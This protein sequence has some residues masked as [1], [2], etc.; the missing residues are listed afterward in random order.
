MCVCVHVCM[1]PC[2]CVN[3]HKTALS[4][5][6]VSQHSFLYLYM[7]ARMRVSRYVCMHVCM[8]VY[9]WACTH[10]CKPVYVS[11]PPLSRRQELNHTH[12]YIH[13]HETTCICMHTVHTHMDASNTL[14]AGHQGPR[15][16]CTQGESNVQR[17]ICMLRKARFRPWSIR[18]RWWWWRGGRR[19]GRA[20]KVW[21][22]QQRL[23][24]TWFE[25]G[26]G[27]S[28][29]NCMIAWLNLEMSA[30]MVYVCVYVLISACLWNREES[31][32]MSVLELNTSTYTFSLARTWEFAGT[33]PSS[34]SSFWI[35]FGEAKDDH[36]SWGLCSPVCMHVCMHACALMC[37][38][39]VP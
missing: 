36:G 19:A 1:H 14:C 4:L 2:V 13:I 28:S 18:W 32:K 30:S 25:Q 37:M 6:H 17:D 22:I 8:C 27:E 24:K 35:S 12:A 26:K 15:D 39:V 21:Q 5:A 7:Y 16:T 23:R 33:V 34:K 31:R 29:G 38:Y 3:V 9:V 20:T 11:F 10:V